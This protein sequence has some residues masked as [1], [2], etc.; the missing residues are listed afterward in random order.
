MIYPARSSQPQQSFRDSFLSSLPQ[1][2]LKVLNPSRVGFDLRRSHAG[3]MRLGLGDVGNVRAFHYITH[4][5]EEDEDEEEE[6]EEEEEEEDEE[7]KEKDEEEEEEKEEKEEKEEEE[8]EKE[9]VV[10][11]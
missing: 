1:A 4:E 5:E 6:D 7:E 11:S 10:I 3:V 2:W 9:V 8:E